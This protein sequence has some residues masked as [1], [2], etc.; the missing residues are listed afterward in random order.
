MWYKWDSVG[1]GKYYMKANLTLVLTIR[2]IYLWSIKFVG[3]LM[4]TRVYVHWNRGS[5]KPKD[6][7]PRSH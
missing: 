3:R 7:F 2:W 6:K 4:H 5:V 1:I